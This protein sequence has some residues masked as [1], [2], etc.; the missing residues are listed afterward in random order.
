LLEFGQALLQFLSEM[1]LHDQHSPQLQRL[2]SFK[3]RASCNCPKVYPAPRTFKSQAGSAVRIRN[4]PW[5]TRP[6]K[7]A[8]NCEDIAD[9]RSTK[10][11]C[12]A[13]QPVVCAIAPNTASLSGLLPA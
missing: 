12:P 7:P 4:S 3:A 10:R 13:V 11:V 1:Q 6:Y 9:R 8:R 5:T 2:K